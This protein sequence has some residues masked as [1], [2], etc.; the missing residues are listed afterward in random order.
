MDSRECLQ[1]NR[2]EPITEPFFDSLHTC[3][4]DSCILECYHNN[5]PEGKIISKNFNPT[6]AGFIDIG[7]HFLSLTRD[8]NMK[9]NINVVGKGTGLCTHMVE[10]TTIEY[11]C[12][13]F[14]WQGSLKVKV[15]T[16]SWWNLRYNNAATNILTINNKDIPNAYDVKSIENVI[17][18]EACYGVLRNQG[19][20]FAVYRNTKTCFLKRAPSGGNMYSSI[21][22]SIGNFNIQGFDIA[23]TTSTKQ[24][25]NWVIKESC[26]LIFKEEKKYWCKSFI[27]DPDAVIVFKNL[28]G[29]SIS[30]R[31]EQAT[32]L[33][34]IKRIFGTLIDAMTTVET[35]AMARDC[36][37]SG[38]N[39]VLAYS[40]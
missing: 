19:Y 10:W 34:P 28:P 33:N 21:G 15:P 17:N 14:L 6:F 23:D 1:N 35:I 31:I 2:Y 29:K 24:V 25:K 32:I 37:D 38:Y 20:D 36:A 22:K 27:S 4:E 13:G 39:P 12:I 9:P 18:I 26:D 30:K 3:N 40:K 16:K 7:N 5:F 8:V 11:H